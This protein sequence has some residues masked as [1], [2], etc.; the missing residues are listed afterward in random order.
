MHPRLRR[1]S[2]QLS[3]IRI[4]R[5]SVHDRPADRTRLRDLEAKVVVRA[6]DGVVVLVNDEVMAFRVTVAFV[7]VDE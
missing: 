5:E 3:T 1:I 6:C 4:A 7:E 2:V